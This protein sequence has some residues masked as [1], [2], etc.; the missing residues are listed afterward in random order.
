M[1]TRCLGYILCRCVR[2]F[3]SS[4]SFHAAVL[5]FNALFKSYPKCK[6]LYVHVDLE[7]VRFCSLGMFCWLYLISWL[8]L[9]WF[10][11][12]I[13]NRYICISESIWLLAK[14]LNSHL[15]KG[16]II[17]FPLIKGSIESHKMCIRIYGTCRMLESL[18][19]SSILIPITIYVSATI[20]VYKRF[21]F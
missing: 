20:D 21:V 11:I 1:S 19:I 7:I 5:N 12:D 10:S 13:A 2:D 18:L 14:P 6:Q 15:M 8:V 17:M 3:N 4:R 9:A 16:Q